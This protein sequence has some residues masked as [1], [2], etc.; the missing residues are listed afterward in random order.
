MRYI[1]RKKETRKFLKNSIVNGPYVMKM[2]EDSV[3]TLDKPIKRLETEDDLTGDEMK[4][5]DVDI[6]AMNLIMFGIPNDIYN[7]ADT[8]EDAR[9]MFTSEARESLV[10]IYER[11]AICDDQGDSLTTAMMLIAQEITQRYSIPTNNRLRTYS[12][13]GNQ[14]IVQADRMDIQSKNVGNADR[15]VTNTLTAVTSRRLLIPIQGDVAG[16]V[17]VQRN[18]GNDTN[19]KRIQRTTANS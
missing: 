18:T 13:T 10:S 4:L 6:E 3:S 11:E 9:A 14:A 1:D 19:V 16:N 8:C 2:I 7:F 17:N 12:N 15:A 5:Y